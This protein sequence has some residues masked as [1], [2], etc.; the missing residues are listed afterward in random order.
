MI[1]NKLNYCK[2]CAQQGT[3]DRN[4]DG[5]L[6]DINGNVYEYSYKCRKCGETTIHP[7]NKYLE[8]ELK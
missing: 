8:G 2:S 1:G 4:P 6:K 3:W 5:D 7:S